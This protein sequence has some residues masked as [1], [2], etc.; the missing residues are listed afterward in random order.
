MRGNRTQCRLMKRCL[1]KC[2][3]V[4]SIISLLPFALIYLVSTDQINRIKNYD[5]S[6]NIYFL[7]AYITED[8]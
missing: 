1:V 5:V 7:G 4:F 2:L 3:L 6:I 8:L